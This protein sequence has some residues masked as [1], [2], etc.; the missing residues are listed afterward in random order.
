MKMKNL[1]TLLVAGMATFSLMACGNGAKKTETS[2]AQSAESS[3]ESSAQTTQASSS[4]QTTV[5]Q[6]MDDNGIRKALVVYFPGVDE[7][8]TE[9]GKKDVQAVAE[10]ISKKANADQF[11]VVPEADYPKTY[12]EY[13]AQ[14]KREKEEKATPAYYGD[15][16]GWNDYSVVYVG[17][18]G[19][20]DSVERVMAKFIQDHKWDG[21]TIVP[22]YT[23]SEGKKAT[24]EVKD[25]AKGANVK[26]ATQFT[27]SQ[28]TGS[29]FDHDI[30]DFVDKMSK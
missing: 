5:A 1:A 14:V 23:A 11:E 15:V 12:A 25:L 22:Y 21:K 3:K 29:S 17:M 24:E 27:H 2:N 28:I 8:S 30:V 16:D 6:S 19:A 9:G 18:Q 10:M 4:A 26:E 13:A 20:D 7:T